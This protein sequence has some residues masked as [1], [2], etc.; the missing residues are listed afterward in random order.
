MNSAAEQIARFTNQQQDAVF[1]QKIEAV[2][3]E[4]KQA[5]ENLTCLTNKL[6]IQFETARDT[7][8]LLNKV[9]YQNILSDPDGNEINIQ[10]ED[11]Q[12]QSSYPIKNKVVKNEDYQEKSVVR[13]PPS[14]YILPIGSTLEVL[15]TDKFPVYTGK[16]LS[17]GTF[18]QYLN[19][20]GKW[21]DANVIHNGDDDGSVTLIN[22][23]GFK[24]TTTIENVRLCFGSTIEHKESGCWLVVYKVE[25]LN[26]YS[27]FFSDAS[28]CA[29][30]VPTAL[31]TITADS[32]QL[33]RNIM[34]AIPDNFHSS[35]KTSR[36]Y[37]KFCEFYED[38]RS[39]HLEYL[40]DCFQSGLV[41]LREPLDKVSIFK[42]VEVLLL[43][44]QMEFPTPPNVPK[45]PITQFK[46]NSM[47]KDN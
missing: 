13:S 43:K 10:T 17:L 42:Q 47:L 5:H 26:T 31:H 28:H 35:V 29:P 16:N 11:D 37:L 4:M 1:A 32:V 22:V 14:S 24:F 12:K 36:S 19:R 3:C 40:Y 39:L 15:V 46:I 7:D 25:D 34:S 9:E 8:L 6:E 27:V 30:I 38:E 18:V 41:V 44:D 20:K 45:S 23:F 33:I 2:N 21:L